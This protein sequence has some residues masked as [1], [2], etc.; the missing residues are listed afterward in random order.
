M[1]SLLIFNK[2]YL[3]TIVKKQAFIYTKGMN[4][5]EENFKKF[6]NNYMLTQ[7][8]LGDNIQLS[9]SQIGNLEKTI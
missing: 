1:T 4:T 7:A 6:R 8:E 2:N 3:S 5:F 9:R